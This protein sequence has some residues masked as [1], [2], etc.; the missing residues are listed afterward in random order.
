MTAATDNGFGWHES[1]AE[2]F[3]DGKLTSEITFEQVRAN[4]N[5]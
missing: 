4:S 5:K 2:V 3:R 1:L